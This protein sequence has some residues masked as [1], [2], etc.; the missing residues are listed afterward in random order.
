MENLYTTKIIKTGSSLAIVIP[1]PILAAM[2]LDRGDQ[3]IF[4]VIQGPT[5]II[6]QLSETEIRRLKPGRD[7]T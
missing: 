7:I 6:R 5:L 3:V 2:M 1:K 4:S